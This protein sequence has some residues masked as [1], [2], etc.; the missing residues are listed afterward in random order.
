[1]D[2][3]TFIIAV[4]GAGRSNLLQILT[5]A[6]WRGRSCCA[7]NGRHDETV[8]VEAA[9]GKLATSSVEVS[10]FYSA[11]R[12]IGCAKNADSQ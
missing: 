11:T 4:S 7:F 9:Y 12:F 8:G 5:I 6:L 10:S 2:H 3:G 1:M